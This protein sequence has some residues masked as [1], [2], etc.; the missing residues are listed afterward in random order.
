[1][2]GGSGND[3]MY[4]GSNGPQLQ[5]IESIYGGS[6]NDKMQDLIGNDDMFGQKGVD[7][8][9]GGWG[10]DYLFA[11]ETDLTRDEI[12]ISSQTGDKLSG[13]PGKDRFD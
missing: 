6:G 9:N 1:M 8:V 13:G 11:G 10:D 4:G 3:V 12:V 5:A 2:W 7:D